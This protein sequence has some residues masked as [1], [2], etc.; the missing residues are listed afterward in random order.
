MPLVASEI[1][2]RPKTV[3]ASCAKQL[4]CRPTEISDVTGIEKV[5]RELLVCASLLAKS[6][7]D[8]FVWSCGDLERILRSRGEGCVSN[9][10]ETLE[11]RETV[12]PE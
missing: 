6:I 3:G 7:A 5:T 4:K 1:T 11:A 8:L 9:C 10:L 12:G 2:S